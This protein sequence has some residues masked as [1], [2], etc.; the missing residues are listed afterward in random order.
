[1]KKIFG[2]IEDHDEEVCEDK[3]FTIFRQSLAC[4]GNPEGDKTKFLAYVT[5][6]S[7]G[8]SSDGGKGGDKSH[9][10]SLGNGKAV[11]A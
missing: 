11:D 2:Y 7:M 8:A 4:P 9:V 5:A 10:P 3:F 6:L 1:M